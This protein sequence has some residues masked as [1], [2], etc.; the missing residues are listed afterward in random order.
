M[1][2]AEEAG[3]PACWAYLVC[4]D[5]GAVESEGHHHPGCRLGQDNGLTAG[6]ADRGDDEH[7]TRDR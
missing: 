1:T 4:P 6:V 7:R 3:D 2:Q 5:C